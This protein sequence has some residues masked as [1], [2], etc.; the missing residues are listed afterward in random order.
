MNRYIT[1]ER[2]KVDTQSLIDM[3]ISSGWVDSDLVLVSCFP[4]YSD[5][6]VQSINHKLSYLNQDELFEKID[7]EI[8]YPVMSQVWDKKEGNYIS[9][10]R[11]IKEWLRGIDKSR[12]YLFVENIASKEILKLFTQ[13]RDIDYK[14]ACLYSN[15]ESSTP[16]FLVSR[17]K[18]K[19][20]LFEWENINNPNKN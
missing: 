3:I 18:E 8:P 20:I 13:L 10:D 5:R 1:F 9:F 7:L 6:L 16:N 14:R 17:I 19:K 12:K 4:S 11:Y 2:E 15:I